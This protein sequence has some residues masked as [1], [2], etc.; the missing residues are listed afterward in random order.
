[1]KRLITFGLSGFTTTCLLSGNALSGAVLPAQI[2][3]AM[4]ETNRDVIVIM[5][6][7]AANVPPVRRAL[8]ARAATLAAS[9]SSVMSSL[10]Q[11]SG[12]KFHAFSLVNAFATSVNASELKQLSADARV[13]AVVPDAVIR[14][15]SHQQ[16]TAETPAHSAST[17][18]TDGGL[19]NTLEPELLQATNTAFADPSIPQ[20]QQVRDGNGQLVTGKG[21]KVAYIADGLDP[22]NLAF[23]RPDGSHVF[24]D[25]QDFTGDPAGTPTGGE[26][27]FGD[28]G[29]I[30]AQD[31]PN[32]KPL[33][34]DISQFVNS[35][36]A[37]P[38][39]CNIRIRG[40]APG[41]SLVGL[42]VFGTA[43][44]TTTSNFVQAIEYAVIHDDVDVINE[45][46]G[47]N[48]LPDNTNDPISLAND[49]AVK[50]G[51]TVVVSTGDAG[52][53]DTLGSPATSA[54]SIAAGA[55]TTFRIY[56]Q[57]GDGIIPFATNAGFIDNNISGLSSGG[58]AQK[59][60]RT[61]DVVAPGDLGWGLCSTNTALFTDCFN[62]RKPAVAT[63]IV[64]FGGTSEASPTTSGLAALVIQA[65]RSTHGGADP[66][67]ATVKNII[68][69]TARDLTVPSSEQG[70]G[71]INSLAAVN[72]ALS[73]NDENG[74]RQNRG[75][76]ILIAPSSAHITA[77]PNHNESR[78]FTITNEGSS[79]QHLTPTIE[80]LGPTLAGAT[81]NLTL[82]P[83]TD[84]TFLNV[85][86]NM[87]AYVKQSFKV[88]AG[89]DHLDAAIA[90]QTKIGSSNPPLVFFGLLD[91]SGR[92]AAYSIPQGLGSGYGHVDVANPQSGKW[93]VI[94]YTRVT[95]VAGSYKGP[96][97]FVWG[98]ENFVKLGSVSPAQLDLA[99]GE[100]AAVTAEFSMPASSGDSAAALRFERSRDAASAKFAQ[101]PVSLRTLIPT[102]PTGGNF[103]GTLTGGNSRAGTGPTQTFEFNVPQGVNDMS[104]VLNIADN[105]YLLEG[106]LVDP[107]G[108]QLSVAPNQDPLNGSAQFA[109]QLSHYNP[110]PGRWKF[111]LLQNF[112]SSGNQTTLP[113]TA[114]I[115]FNS[116]RISAPALPNSATVQLSASAA[117]LTVPITVV[118]NGALTQLYFADAR[119]DAQTFTQ[120]PAQPGGC[121]GPVVTLPGFCALNFLP[122]QVSI[123]A[124]AA[125]SSVPITMDAF[126][127]VGTGVGGTGNPDIF[128]RK[129][130]QDA[131]VALISE[132]EVPYS[133][134]FSIPSQ[135][136]PYGPAGAPTV[137]ATASAF[138]SM[139]PFDSAVSADSGDIWA[140]L[141]LNTNTFSPLVLAP[142]QTGTINVTITPDATQQG[143]TVTGFI[144]V[145]TFNTVVTT[146]DEVVRLPYSYTVS[147]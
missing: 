86:G 111:V 110:Q 87:R 44:P 76:G 93:T 127:S 48:P 63:P 66:S 45:S 103:T 65:Y 54:T 125:Q 73:I 104:L 140:D 23:I 118:N 146:G 60:A 132:P 145:D 147:K 139:K 75:A 69:S 72:E 12:R 92:Q 25:Y 97:Q 83:A 130:G 102:E 46:F 107:N 120:L 113:F 137:P 36:H 6:D 133:A 116:A 51:V 49:A 7:Q 27:A 47:G 98:T 2:Q 1:M 15:P 122:T 115:G 9:Q 17:G 100:S 91:P 121:S 74:R 114:R 50:A 41:A 109:V 52:T 4:Q 14:P 43:N 33:F 88:P 126:N 94:V 99:P 141:V 29:T 13:Q 68:M 37:L 3:Q 128:A 78:S 124:F 32:G 71:L 143:K 55:S 82:D 67:P 42:N 40:M 16:H 119:L 117:P 79:V 105:G 129:I 19:C 134:W 96:V 112:T 89:M 95:G 135:V 18:A 58:F 84:P 30:A 39:P 85:A 61:V 64:A 35:V 90:F 53:A 123:A 138:V 136:G 57:T 131:V 22:N 101:V 20:A 34:Y 8:S 106:L 80:T 10:P 31:M 38:S 142:G 81:L 70:A 11:T 21:V 24:I 62:D 5:R 108:M 77:E 144:Y 26:E 59:N 56:A 28:A